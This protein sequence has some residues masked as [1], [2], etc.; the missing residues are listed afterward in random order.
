[1]IRSFLL[2]IVKVNLLFCGHHMCSVITVKKSSSFK[3]AQRR[4]LSGSGFKLVFLFLSPHISKP[5]KKKKKKKKKIL[6]LCIRFV[7]S[8]YVI[9]NILPTVIFHVVFSLSFSL[10]AHCQ[11]TNHLVISD[12]G[13]ERK[14][15]RGMC[16][17]A[18][19]L[20][21]SCSSSPWVCTL[22]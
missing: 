10:R 5:K 3:C 14:L 1:M 21:T 2:L 15:L 16:L 17:R 6:K 9:S 12:N 7:A 18:L 13:F 22:L 4:L 11:I 8:V 20:L 19:K